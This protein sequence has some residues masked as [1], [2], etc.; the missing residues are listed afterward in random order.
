MLTL[1]RTIGG[2][3]FTLRIWQHYWAAAIGRSVFIYDMT[4]PGAP[5]IVHEIRGMATGDD[6]G[7]LALTFNEATHTIDGWTIP[8]QD[9]VTATN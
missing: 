4:G 7:Q 8:W 1:P 3:V 9:S 6:A 2:H 5:E